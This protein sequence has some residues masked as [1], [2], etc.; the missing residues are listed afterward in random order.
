MKKLIPTAAGLLAA[1]LASAP[2]L[3]AGV[4]ADGERLGV[5]AVNIGGSLYVPADS[6]LFDD[7]VGLVEED[8]AGLVPLRLN[9]ERLGWTVNW[10]AE[11]G[12]AVI[13]TDIPVIERLRA[14]AGY[15]L[16]DK[17][18]RQRFESFVFG[19]QDFK[20]GVYDAAS[21]MLEGSGYLQKSPDEQAALLMDCLKLAPF[22]MVDFG[23]VPDF[24]GATAEVGA[25][26]YLPS[27]D[28]WRGAM[29][30][31]W[32]YD[33]TMSDG[34]KMNIFTTVEDSPTV[35]A[36]ARALARFPLAVRRYVKR[37][38][39]LEDGANSYNGG[40]GTVWIRLDRAPGENS[41]ARAL[42]HEL[43]HVLDESLTSDGS[44][45]DKAAD[46]DGTPVS[47][48]GNASREEDLA[49]FS[50][51][52]FMTA[53]DASACKAVGLAYPNRSAAFR[54]LL[55]AADSEEYK[56]F[57]ADFDSLSP[58]ERGEPV[59]RVIA[60]KNSRMALTV[61]TTAL[62]PTLVLKKN[63]GGDAQL[64]WLRPRTNGGVV[65]INKATDCCVS[66]PG[67]SLADG[68]PLV[69]HS[70]PAR[71]SE[72][73][74]VEEREDGLVIRASQSGRYLS[75]SGADIVQSAAETLWTA[76]EPK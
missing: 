38:I 68:Q 60:P 54:A 1:C 33:I 22:A 66:V 37:I 4:V 18:A 13:T 76:E 9:C 25:K 58:Y 30:P 17:N 48:Y 72:T 69:A 46:A 70:G 65:L 55:Y 19:S 52:F 3:G 15:A 20:S 47:T 45:W 35:K 39:Y 26:T 29:K 11:T 6:G 59:Y 44:V 34:Y 36:S 8:G 12:N 75:F 21:A 24:S 51:L 16:L 43:G 62:G 71:P 27:Y 49:E 67:S 2:A 42:A 7:P 32:R 57:K 74:I 41:V 28:V 64:W 53:A 31:V 5:E 56:A 23:E 61:E 63:E 10:N 40:E 50:R 73:W 14:S